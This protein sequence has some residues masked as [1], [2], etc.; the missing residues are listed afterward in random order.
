[1][2]LIILFPLSK[3]NISSIE[4]LSQE[5]RG[6]GVKTDD[7]AHAVDKIVTEV[8]NLKENNSKIL[9]QVVATN[10]RVTN[11][12]KKHIRLEAIAETKMSMANEIKGA[13]WKIAAS[14]VS[15]GII[16]L[17]AA[18]FAVYRIVL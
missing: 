9:A 6:L 7:I 13:L 4:T 15:A 2:K 12:E 16:G 1:M 3:L 5:L 11:L 14:V 18:M 17:G 10:G 8:E